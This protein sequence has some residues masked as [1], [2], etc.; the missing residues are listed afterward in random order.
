[1]IF[2]WLVGLLEG[3]GCFTESGNWNLPRVNITM[4]DPDVVERA[5]QILSGLC[6]CQLRVKATDRSAVGRKTTYNVS[7]SGSR[8]VKVMRHLLD[9]GAMGLRRHKRIE[10]I[11]REYDSGKHKPYRTDNQKA[12][13]IS[14]FRGGASKS[15]VAK[16][17]AL[18]RTDSWRFEKKAK[19][20]E[21]K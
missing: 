7:C 13:I 9:A 14:M 6:E 18:S 1:L 20:I 10:S 3:E 17:F 15:D 5:A 8:A 19:Q 21:E 11:L 12:E 4:T 2:Y 16:M